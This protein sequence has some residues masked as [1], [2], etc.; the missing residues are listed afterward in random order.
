MSNKKFTIGN[1]NKPKFTIKNQ[2]E[3]NKGF[4]IVNHPMEPQTASKSEEENLDGGRFK[5]PVG[6]QGALP[7]TN[8]PFTLDAVIKELRSERDAKITNGSVQ[9]IVRLSSR[10]GRTTR[11]RI[12][13]ISGNERIF[14]VDTR[15]RMTSPLLA[16]PIS[17]P[18]HGDVIFNLQFEVGYLATYD[19]NSFVEALAVN[20]NLAAALNTYVQQWVNEV[21]QAE[22]TAVITNF[23]EIRR[24]LE[25][26]ITQKARQ[27]GI[28]LRVIEFKL[29]NEDVIERTYEIEKSDYLRIQ[30]QNLNEYVE[31]KY[32]ANISCYKPQKLKAILSFKEI[33]NLPL[34]ISKY[35]RILIKEF[36]FG[37]LYQGFTPELIRSLKESVNIKL[38]EDEIGWKIDSLVIT[39]KDSDF[40]IP[41]HL[42]IKEEPMT[43]PIKTGSN[44]TYDVTVFNTLVLNL[45]NSDKAKEKYEKTKN[46]ESLAKEMLERVINNNLLNASYD[47][48]IINKDKYENKIRGQLSEWAYSIGYTINNFFTI[49]DVEIE[50]LGGRFEFSTDESIEYKTNIGDKVKLKVKLNNVEL[51]ELENIRHYLT[52]KINIVEE[53]KKVIVVTVTNF[54]HDKD[55]NDYYVNFET[56]LQDNLKNEIRKSLAAEFFIN[57]N[58]IILLER[59]NTQLIERSLKLRQGIHEFKFE[60]FGSLEYNALFSINAIDPDGW[61]VFQN[62]NFS[63]KETELA[64]IKKHLKYFLE[65]KI[66]DHL[67]I[68]FK[69][70]K[71]ERFLEGIKQFL[72]LAENHIKEKFGLLIEI[73]GIKREATLAEEQLKALDDA[74]HTKMIGQIESETN[75][76][77]EINNNKVLDYQRL[78]AELETAKSQMDDERVKEIE[79]ELKSIDKKTF[80]NDSLINKIQQLEEGLDS[81]NSLNKL[82]SGERETP[83]EDV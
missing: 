50:K 45:S 63:N 11:F 8:N 62:H 28:S 10:T 20:Q 80:R 41:E 81:N 19:L 36:S 26:A 57:E 9:K 75:V 54:L 18:N 34:R 68:T 73:T 40:E 58:V 71:D 77:A 59:I 53:M 70:V 24:R 65:T 47:D 55:P 64:S 72:I 51:K 74:N 33:E 7:F 30:L 5:T 52:P 15:S 17:L 48:L 44:Q 66:N 23:F 38:M 32:Q 61:Q 56:T 69:N 35:L 2:K 83:Q 78:R 13:F 12:P 14:F 22:G 82:P 21:I 3:D 60:S 49:P 4:T 6:E 79:K 43:F 27:L 46:L 31:I 29:N 42:T 1:S 67:S 39:K 16:Y 76:A 25:Q 37:Q